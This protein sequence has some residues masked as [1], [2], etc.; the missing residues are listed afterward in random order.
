MQF[1]RI[2]LFMAW[3][4]VAWATFRAITTMGTGPAGQIFLSDMA[5][6]WRGQFNIDFLIHLL[7]VALWLGVTARHKWLGPVIGLFA[8]LGGG[9]FTCAYLLVRSYGGDGSLRHLLLG[10]RHVAGDARA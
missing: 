10:R 8:I 5:H 6:P 1:T 9:V 7:L 3:L 2:V 4:I